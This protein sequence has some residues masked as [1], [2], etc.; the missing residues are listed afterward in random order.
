VERFDFV[1][2]GAGSAGEAAAYEARERGASVAVV[3]RDLFGGS[4]PHWGCVPSK[5]LLNGA[6]RRAT[7]EASRG[8]EPPR[9]VTT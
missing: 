1:I 6:A 3:D 2:I 9:D 5:S 8:S 7:G 4:C